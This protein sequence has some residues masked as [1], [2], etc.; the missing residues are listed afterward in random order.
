M[1]K[2]YF[3]YVYS[4]SLDNKLHKYA[5]S[6]KI[7]KLKKYLK[8]VNIY[9]AAD[10][11]DTPLSLA[12]SQRNEKA[13]EELF[14]IYENDFNFIRKY[15]KNETT[16]WWQEKKIF[17]AYGPDEIQ[18]VRN[19]YKEIGKNSD[20]S[21]GIIIFLKED[22]YKPVDLIWIKNKISP[23]DHSKAL[24]LFSKI[25]KNGVFDV[26]KKNSHGDSIL[27]IA[28]FN[29]LTQIV[30]RL[31]NNLNAKHNEKNSFDH[32][33]LSYACENGQL[34]TLK[35]LISKLDY[36]ILEPV[37][38]VSI[39]HTAC[40]QGEIE[41]FCFMIDKMVE[42]RIS[43]FKESKDDA[44]K[45]IINESVDG[46]GNPP[47][48]SALEFNNSKFAEEILKFKPDLMKQNCLDQTPLHTAIRHTDAKEMC[49]NIIWGNQKLLSIED[50]SGYNP[51]HLMAVKGWTEVFLKCF[52]EIPASKEI[53]LK[54]KKLLKSILIEVITKEYLLLT[55]IIF[56]LLRDTL[57][58]EDFPK[59]LNLAAKSDD[60]E[61]LKLLIGHPESD[62]NLP[63]D[64]FL[65]YPLISALSS[66][67][68]LN[69]NF[70]LNLPDLKDINQIIDRDENNLLKYAIWEKGNFNDYQCEGSIE[71]IH[72]ND[73]LSDSS[74]DEVQIK[75]TSCDKNI[76]LTS[77]NSIDYEG[78]YLE[79]F[80]NLIERKVDYN[81][82]NV[83]G[84]NLLFNAVMN[85]NLEILLELLNLGV[86]P[87]A[88][89]TNQNSIL[90]FIDDVDIL[91]EII[92]RIS[93]AKDF[94]NLKNRKGDTALHNCIQKCKYDNP[95]TDLL[96][97]LIKLGANVNSTNNNL[98][99][100]LH[101]VRNEEWCQILIKNGA[102]P[103]MKDYENNTP[104]HTALD[105]YCFKVGIF[106]LSIPGTDFNSVN[107]HG[108][109]YLCDLVKIHEIKPDDDIMKFFKSNQE[110]IDDMFKMHCNSLDR[111]GDPVLY[112]A[113]LNNEYCF[114]KII[115]QKSLKVI[116]GNLVVQNAVKSGNLKKVQSLIKKGIEFSNKPEESP[117]FL[118][119]EQHLIEICK[120]LIES[121]CELN[122][123]DSK[124]D[125]PLHCAAYHN[126]SE[127]ICC[128]IENGADW[129]LRNKDGYLAW[130][131]ISNDLKDVY[132][133]LF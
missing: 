36:D 7:D 100:P 61:I 17:I 126:L 53:L 99:N 51:L 110:K 106:L 91:K 121:K 132:E 15:F 20:S 114:N 68:F 119:I 84:F 113:A 23:E 117:L 89:D 105:R 67:K 95:N 129:K 128:L 27:H 21:T 38:H 97:E 71:E 77:K 29:G 64:D 70:L 98:A 31:I 57:K 131:L 76:K 47:F 11:G 13:Y 37:G 83:K 18:E 82:R 55:E 43:Q 19:F 42:A 48:Q 56:G 52:E 9:S 90:H 6:G 130:D 133:F 44:L 60:T 122:I 78:N 40:F 69:F 103:N 127:I 63:D 75:I 120:E 80:H 111:N 39:A 1:P 28:A 92:S 22:N 73:V 107:N 45:F 96:K 35:E 109:S 8:S 5:F 87:T 2:N 34:E 25:Y 50:N 49:W 10:C 58:K 93:P 14:K 85:N 116:S 16:N 124:V 101:L 81:F 62:Q 94:I 102:S 12:V 86:D 32:T 108:V 4:S 41:T 59:L 74:D 65:Q 88:C 118:A 30:F 3:D 72:L 125:T 123:T 104:I 66:K 115:E 33:I 46:S 26:N 24:K 54:N 112:S 79:I